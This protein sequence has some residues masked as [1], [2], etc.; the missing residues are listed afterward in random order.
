MEFEELDFFKNCLFFLGYYNIEDIS[1]KLVEVQ[2]LETAIKK[3]AIISCSYDFGSFKK[4]LKLKPLK[5][6]NY[7]GFWYLIA[8]DV[9]NDILK[10]Y[11]LKNIA[12]I[13]L[14]KDIFKAN[15]KLEDTLDNSLSIWFDED[16]EPFEVK[17]LISSNIA[18]YWI[19][20]IKVLEPVWIREIIEK[21]IRKF[22]V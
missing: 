14:S 19:P 17:L 10:K 5:I 11:Y 12:K 16:K 7:E 4:E 3:R 2:Q 13:E 21:D 9:R 20:H 1:D 15:S 22:L 18:K 8:L 6:A